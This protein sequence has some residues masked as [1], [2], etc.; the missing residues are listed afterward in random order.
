MYYLKTRWNT[1]GSVERL[2]AYAL[3]FV[4]FPGLLVLSPFV[5]LRPQPRPLES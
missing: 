5:N 3:V 4:F 1:M 2:L